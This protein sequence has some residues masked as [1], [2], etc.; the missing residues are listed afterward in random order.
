M[1]HYNSYNSFKTKRSMNKK[2]KAKEKSFT[3]KKNIPRDFII[4]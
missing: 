3:S 1:P 4:E 2:K